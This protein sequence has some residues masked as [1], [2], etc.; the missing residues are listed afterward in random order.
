VSA[1]GQLVFVP[2][3]VVHHHSS[4]VGCCCGRAA[5]VA[6]VHSL[7]Y[8]PSWDTR[9]AA[10]ATIGLLAEAFPHHSVRHLAAAA[11]STGEQQADAQQALQLQDLQQG[12][13]ITLQTF[14]LPSV[15]SKGEPL[16]ASGGQVGLTLW[17]AQCQPDI[18]LL[19]SLQ[20]TALPTAQHLVCRPEQHSGVF[21][22]AVSC[23]SMTWVTPTCPWRSGWPSS[24]NKSR[25]A[26]VS[27]IGQISL[28]MHAV[29]VN[30]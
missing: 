10:A 8:S 27:S 21:A 29:G 12:V 30:E 19:P 14:D 17:G 16:L 4:C 28:V 6:Q 2:A 18:R 5:A 7:L 20:A 26:W 23:R 22:A 1:F 24:E 3:T 15:L 13:H 11:A 9:T 25:S